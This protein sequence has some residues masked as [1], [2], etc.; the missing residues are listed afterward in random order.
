MPINSLRSSDDTFEAMTNECDRISS[1]ALYNPL[2]KSS[3]AIKELLEKLR[4]QPMVCKECIKPGLLTFEMVEDVIFNSLST[5]KKFK[6]LMDAVLAASN[7]NSN[8]LFELAI[9]R[10]ESRGDSKLL[11]IMCADNNDSTHYTLKQ[12]FEK[13][14][15]IT[16]STSRMGGRQWAWRLL[17]CRH[18][19][20]YQNQERYTGP[21]NTPL[22]EKVLI[23]G[24][25]YDPVT[26]L[27]SAKEAKRLM[28]LENGDSNAVLLIQNGF[29]HGS[30]AHPS[31]C[32]F[33][34]MRNYIFNGVVPPDGTI[35]E[36]SE[37]LFPTAG[38][39]RDG[40]IEAAEQINLI[41]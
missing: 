24:N 27:Y 19:K 3:D 1:C 34:Y 37:S 39:R 18:W 26:P 21:W 9:K 12:W 23:I 14:E 8:P 11:A 36:P 32:T 10:N 31:K 16:K 13:V 38:S 20:R 17:G 6:G 41:N 25:R 35:C 40:L 5:P 7:G 33:D 2:K 28:E 4:T 29:G 22:A 15:Q 30:F